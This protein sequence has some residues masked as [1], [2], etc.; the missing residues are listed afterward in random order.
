MAATKG[1]GKDT[2]PA[3]D[4]AGFTDAL[5]ELPEAVEPGD[6]ELDAEQ[7]SLADELGFSGDQALALKRLVESFL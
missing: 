2:P 1:F 7:Q 6:S 5:D 4:A 3:E